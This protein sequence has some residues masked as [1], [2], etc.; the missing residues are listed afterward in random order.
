[1]RY[2]DVR[3]T[4]TSSLT[5]DWA[6]LAEGPYYLDQLAQVS[7]PE[8]HWIEIDSHYHLAVYKPDVSIRL[9]WG[10]R[11]DYRLVFDG[12][13]WPANSKDIARFI[14]D[15]FWGGALVARWTLLVV[16]EGH[17]YL[18]DPHRKYTHMD[19]GALNI[20]AGP[21]LAT[22]GEIALA[23]LLNNLVG[24]DSGEFERY[25]DATGITEVEDDARR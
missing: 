1:M 18:P 20:E 14:V 22:T 4:V 17:C 24:R 21:W 5:T 7:G 11:Q 6:L 10:I 3:N 19:N 12:W 15:V 23:Q 2:D 9:A 25:F 8:G 13:Q 16:D